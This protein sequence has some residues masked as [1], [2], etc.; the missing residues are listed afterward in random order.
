MAEGAF[1][2]AMQHRG[3]DWI[4]DSAGTASYHIGSQPDPRAIAIA[5]ANGVDITRQSA[6][7]ITPNDFFRFD[8]IIALD[9]ANLEGI[10]AHA[11][12]DGTATISLLLD[13]AESRAGQSVA[14]PYHGSLD[15]FAIVWMVISDAVEAL[16]AR[17]MID[18]AKAPG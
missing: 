12:R 14:D 13:A 3:L 4:V 7:Q 18:N 8:H 15:D 16:V 6:R 9:R 17:L 2:V 10:K 11:P 1:R 5:L